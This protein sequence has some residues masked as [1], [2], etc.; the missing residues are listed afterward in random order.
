MLYVAQHLTKNLTDKCR[1]LNKVLGESQVG[2]RVHLIDC[3][4]LAPKDSNNLSDPYVM[5]KH[6]TDVSKFGYK[7]R[8]LFV[9]KVH[10]KTLTTKW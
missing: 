4:D 5:I 1:T 8:S 7:A 9:S 10:P 2:L 6:E 3:K